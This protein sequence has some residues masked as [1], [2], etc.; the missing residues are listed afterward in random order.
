VVAIIPARYQ[1]TRFPGKSLALIDDRT[2][3]EHVHRRASEASSVDAVLVAT[4]D[5]RIAE[6]V[7]RFGGTAVLTRADHASGTDRLAEVAA[8]LSAGIIV[9]VQGDEPLVEPSAIDA[10]VAPL[11]GRSTADVSTLRRRI[12]GPA[13]AADPSVVKVVIDRDG[14][15]LYFSRLPIPFVREGAASPGHWHHLGLY[16]YRRDALRR[17]A[18]L[19]PGALE[20]AEG[21]E[22]LRALE[23]GIPIRVLVV[24]R[25]APGV[26]TPEDLARVEA[27]LAARGER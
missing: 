17:W 3:I 8:E 4:D 22:Q 1:S 11:L 5:R 19:P 13:D 15:A 10:A 14:F 26:D 18:A 6:A 23:H 20:L 12:T 25:A 9:N 16:V 2:M 7:D 27:L 21:L 24:E